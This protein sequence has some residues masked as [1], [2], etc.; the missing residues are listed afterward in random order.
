MRTF[1]ILLVVISLGYWMGYWHGRAYE[2]YI[3]AQHYGAIPKE[4][5]WKQFLNRK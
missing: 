3:S 2:L 4:M 5:T 1:V